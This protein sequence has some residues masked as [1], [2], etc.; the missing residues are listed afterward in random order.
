MDFSDFDFVNFGPYVDL[1]QI[2]LYLFWAFF[3]YLLFYIQKETRREG[4]PLES[5]E[6][7]AVV[8]HG[9]IYMPDAKVFKLPHGH[10]DVALPDY[11]RESRK[12]NLEPSEPWS[13]APKDPTGSNPMLDGVGPGAWAERA[14]VPD[15]MWSGEVKIKPMR[16]ADVYAI[17]SGD[18][19][20][21]G[22]EVKGCDDAVGG[23]V[24]DVWVDKAESVIRYYEIKVSDDPKVR[25]VLMPA[26]FAVVRT[27]PETHLYVDA[28]TGSQF[29]DVPLTKDPETITMLEEEKIMGYYG[30]GFFYAMP[31]RAN[32][33]V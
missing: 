10:G 23:T 16:V 32:P 25:T 20:P 27:K 1:A 29:A 30:A 11:K 13:G 6:T 17:P 2:L 33:L 12:L 5:D 4:Y 21:I 19:N 24:V 9:V 22:G 14:D 26:N 28:I 15:Q 7:G 18:P 31:D 3:A 8:N